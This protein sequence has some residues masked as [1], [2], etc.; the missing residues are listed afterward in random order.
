MN[1]TTKKE[2][3]YIELDGSEKY[4]GILEFQDNK[5]EYHDFQVVS[6][7]T[8]LIFGGSCNVG[9]IQSGYLEKEE[10]ETTDEALQELLADLE[11]FYNDGPAYV[12][13]IV[14]NERM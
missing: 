7:P 4:L 12:S 14:C 5:E 3:K 13:R 2:W 6:T 8:H 1:T 9:F 11:V 10:G